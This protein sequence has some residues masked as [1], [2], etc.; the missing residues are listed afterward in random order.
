MAFFIFI[1][2]PRS[3]ASPLPDPTGIIASVV[4]LLISVFPTSFTDPS[5]PTATIIS[6]LLI[7]LVVISIACFALSVYLIS[8]SYMLLSKCEAI[9]FSAIFCLPTPEIGLIINNM[10]FFLLMTNLK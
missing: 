7:L 6:Y 5:P 4:S 8:A 9:N 10:F 3:L 1:G 2:I